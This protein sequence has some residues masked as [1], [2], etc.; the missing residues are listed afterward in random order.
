MRVPHECKARFATRRVR[1][2]ARRWSRS[3][4]T[5]RAGRRAGGASRR[6]KRGIRTEVGTAAVPRAVGK[7]VRIRQSRRTTGRHIA[8]RSHLQWLVVVLAPLEIVDRGGSGG[9]VAVGSRSAR[10]LG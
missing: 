1:D 10:K 7:Q 5:A 6:P 8:E 2:R 3:C 9:G 4:R